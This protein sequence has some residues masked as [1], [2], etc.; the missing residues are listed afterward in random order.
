MAECFLVKGIAF[1]RTSFIGAAISVPFI[2]L[3]WRRFFPGLV[4]RR[5]GMYVTGNVLVIGGGEIARRIIA[6]LEHDS[7]A[8]VKG[9]V[10]AQSGE[11]PAQAL[12]YPVVGRVSDISA[13]LNSM[14]ID[15]L[16]IAARENWHSH[17]VE[18]LPT[19]K[20]RSLVIRW[21]PRDLFDRSEAA[22]PEDIPLRNFAL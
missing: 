12:G 14:N 21:V 9:I 19:V 17:L 5:T 4:S 1:S 20:D 11:V 10:W 7:S 16:I 15:Q 2:L 3:A 18:A 22:L 8:S 6:N 13:I